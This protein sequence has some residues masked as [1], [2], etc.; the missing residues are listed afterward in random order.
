MIKMMIKELGGWLLVCL[1]AAGILLGLTMATA[2]ASTAF[3]IKEHRPGL[4]NV[5]CYYRDQNRRSHVISLPNGS[6]CPATIEVD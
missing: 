3:F 5:L 1:V 4:G 2:E 6:K